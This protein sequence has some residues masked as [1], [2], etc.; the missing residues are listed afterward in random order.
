MKPRK[1]VS[2]R[3]KHDVHE[4]LKE[5]AEKKKAT[6]SRLL[7]NQAVSLI[8]KEKGKRRKRDE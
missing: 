8:K 5:V 3:M 6:V 1:V 2:I 7:E 4:E